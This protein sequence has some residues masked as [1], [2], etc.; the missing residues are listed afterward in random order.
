MKTLTFGAFTL[1]ERTK[2]RFYEPT[3]W[4]SVACHLCPQQCVIAPSRS[5]SC[6]VRTN[7]S[8]VLYLDT[9]GK[10]AYHEVVTADDIPLYH[11]MPD[12]DWMLLGGKGCTMACPFCNT[13][14]FSQ[15]GA[16]R[17]VPADPDRIID[18][19]LKTNIH[20][21]SFGISEPAPMHEFIYDVFQLARRNN[22]ATHLSTSGLWSLDPFQEILSVT[23]A[24]TFGMKGLSEQLYQTTL[25]GDLKTSLENL[26]IAS[27]KSGVHVEV[28]WLLIP[29]ITDRGK[30]IETLMKFLERVDRHPPL[31]LL[32]YTPAFTWKGAQFPAATLADLEAFRDRLTNY[33][34]PVYTLHSDCKDLN[35]RCQNCGRTLVRRGMVR[36][37][38]TQDVYTGKPRDKCPQCG[39]PA[40]YVVRR[41]GGK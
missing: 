25:S 22:I 8:G 36:S 17:A 18:R 6:G 9:W 23:D 3:S 35:T 38:I 28:T 29:T 12:I 34:G 2:A 21:I 7:R 30:D 4:D 41:E 40:P 31:L 20:G 32:P 26:R 19:C 11:Y 13:A 15:S 16:V 37:V 24:V 5:G 33:T 1:Q 14:R 39:A 10:L 27:A